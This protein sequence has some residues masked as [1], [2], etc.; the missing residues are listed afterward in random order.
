MLFTIMLFTIMGHPEPIL[1]VSVP[2]YGKF[3]VFTNISEDELAKIA[4]NIIF[5]NILVKYSY[6]KFRY[7]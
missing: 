6:R 3:T 1:I 7:F 5:T 2:D 4:K